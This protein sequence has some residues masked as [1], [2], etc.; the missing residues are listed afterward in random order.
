LSTPGHPKDS[1]WFVL[2]NYGWKVC[3]CVYRICTIPGPTDNDDKGQASA[4]FRVHGSDTM[5]GDLHTLECCSDL[6]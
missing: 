5:P 6:I 3:R 1:A 2:S 4:D